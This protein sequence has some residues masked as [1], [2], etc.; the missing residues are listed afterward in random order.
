M[1]FVL[2]DRVKE[3]TVTTGTGTVILDGAATASGQAL[4]IRLDG[5]VRVGGSL[6]Y[7]MVP[8]HVGV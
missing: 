7:R 1:S 4:C 2:A 8:D 6:A 3:T 5:N